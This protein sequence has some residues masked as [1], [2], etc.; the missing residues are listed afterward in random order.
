VRRWAA[1]AALV[2][3]L[4]AALG[5]CGRPAGVDG[6][7][8]DDWRPIAEAR[9]FVPRAGT[10]TLSLHTATASLSAYNPVD[11]AEDHQAETVFV[12]IFGGAATE[13]AAPPPAGSPAIREAYAECDR[14]TRAYLGDDWRV[15]GLWLGLT[16]PSPSAWSGGGRWYRCEVAEVAPE[17]FDEV[18]PRRGSLAG[19]L[20]PSSPLRLGCFAVR[21]ADG[22]VDRMRPVTC[23][24]AHRAEFVGVYTAPPE[25]PYPKGDDQRDAFLQGCRE[26]LARFANVPNDAD[27]RFRTGLIWIPPRE[28]EWQAGDRGVRCY[29]WVDDRDLKRS[30][31]NAGPAGLPVR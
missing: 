20:T 8:A 26:P 18:R 14:R 17:D 15:A 28:D 16:L 11:C 22:E 3:P 29:L 2:G 6:D 4:L 9:P 7:I 24:A 13:A 31:R 12:G 5:G 23:E 21:T 27:L 10:C 1:V 30:M 19:A 25:L